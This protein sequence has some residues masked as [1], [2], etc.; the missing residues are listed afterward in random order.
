MKNS[1]RLA[2]LLF[3]LILM[4]SLGKITF[5]ANDLSISRIMPDGIY[6]S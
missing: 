5:A 4:F 3:A 2:A 1:K 6:E